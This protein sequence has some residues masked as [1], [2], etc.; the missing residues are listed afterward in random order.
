MWERWDSW[1]AERGFQSPG[2]N[3]FNHYAYGA[4]GQWLYAAVAGIELDE[5]APGGKRLRIAPRPGGGL[6]WARGELRTMY[7]RVES[8][9]RIADGALTLK[10]SFPANAGAAVVLPAS[11]PAAVTEGGAPLADAEGV[12]NVRVEAGAVRCD[13]AAGEYEFRMPAG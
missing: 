6:T 1:T 4:I 5:D 9:W 11:D 10:L 8:H 7:G 12:A 13:V 3:S 2:M